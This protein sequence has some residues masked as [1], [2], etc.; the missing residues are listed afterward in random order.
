MRHVSDKQRRKNFINGFISLLHYGG[1]VTYE[2]FPTDPW[3]H[4]PNDEII[5][6]L[7]IW[8]QFYKESVPLM[9]FVEQ[10]LGSPKPKIK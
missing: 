2:K 4:V 8:E 10:T 9:Q 5:K 6:V 1:R 7:K 3:Q